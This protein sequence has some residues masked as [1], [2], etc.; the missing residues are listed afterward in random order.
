M[1]PERHGGDE[2][3]LTLGEPTCHCPLLCWGSRGA[4]RT[5]LNATKLIIN[6]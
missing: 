1:S 6:S 4:R 3:H 5:T 2:S